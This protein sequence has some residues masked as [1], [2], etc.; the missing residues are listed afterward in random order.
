MRQLIAALASAGLLFGCQ[1]APPADPRELARQQHVQALAS[2]DPAQALALE[3]SADAL[4][5]AACPT[6]ARER[7]PVLLHLAQLYA[8]R[9]DRDGLT[10]CAL[11]ARSAGRNLDA[12]R[13]GDWPLLRDQ[14]AL[15]ERTGELARAVQIERS[16]LD[17]KLQI[18]G[19]SHPQ[20]AASRARIAQ[21]ELRRAADPPPVG[22]APPD[23]AR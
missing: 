16:L 2:S 9:G 15:Y 22:A 4:L 14:S 23:P 13:L 20:V 19:N 8:A 12:S 7:I 3:E 17:A 11:R 21:L 1:S 10:S 6:C 18:V 5:A